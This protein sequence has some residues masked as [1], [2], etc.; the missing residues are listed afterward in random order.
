MVTHTTLLK[1][2]C[3]GSNVGLDLILHLLLYCIR[4]STKEAFEQISI[5]PDLLF[6]YDK[7]PISQIHFLKINKNKSGFILT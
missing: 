4:V 3:H 6:S 5:S 7:R 2:S 1:I